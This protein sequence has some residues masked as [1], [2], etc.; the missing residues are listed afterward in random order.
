MQIRVTAHRLSIRS[1]PVPSSLPPR[2]TG[3]SE[4]HS[5]R[6]EPFVKAITS[7][8]RMGASP[9]AGRL[10]RRIHHGHVRLMSELYESDILRAFYVGFS[11]SVGPTER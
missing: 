6:H 11:T 10:R 5:R 9:L 1:A 2:L 4:F 8:R 7:R 3:T